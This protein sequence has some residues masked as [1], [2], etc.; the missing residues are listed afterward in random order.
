M[1]GQFRLANRDRLVEAGLC[2]VGVIVIM[3]GPRHF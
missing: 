1:G 2:F 3:F